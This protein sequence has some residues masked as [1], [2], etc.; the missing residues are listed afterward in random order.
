MVKI[1]IQIK[2]KNISKSF[3]LPDDCELSVSNVYYKIKY[4][5]DEIL[6]HDENDDVVIVF[7]K[8]IKTK[9]DLPIRKLE[10]L[11]QGDEEFKKKLDEL[12]N[13]EKK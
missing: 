12:L 13:G 7:P 5:F 4:L 6:R 9:P 10:R 2:D 3:S 8:D 1:Q 11:Y